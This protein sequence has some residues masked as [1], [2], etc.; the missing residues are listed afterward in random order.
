M[1]YTKKAMQKEGKSQEEMKKYVAD[2]MTGDYNH[3][4]SISSDIIAK[5]NKGE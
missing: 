1:G 5:L 3:L 4:L 2:A